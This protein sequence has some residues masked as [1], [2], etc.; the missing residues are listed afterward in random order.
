MDGDVTPTLTADKSR[1][2]TP[3]PY[4]Y[5]RQMSS[6]YP[7]HVPLLRE[8]SR[9]IPLILTLTADKSRLYTPYLYPYHVKKAVSIPLTLTLTADK[10][11]L[12]TLYPP[13]YC[14]GKTPS[15]YSLPIPLLRSHCSIG[16]NRYFVYSLP[17]F[18]RPKVTVRFTR[19]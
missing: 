18:I 8:K 3:Y 2:Y 5:C 6:L 15:P 12:Y 13:P 1:L 10:S 9:P 14:G 17:P 19:R 11:R 4:P 7:L 16:P